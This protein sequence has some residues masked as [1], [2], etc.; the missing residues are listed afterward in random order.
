MAHRVTFCDLNCLN[1]PIRNI[2]NGNVRMKKEEN[3]VA[4]VLL[5]NEE[6]K[7]TGRWFRETK[8]LYCKGK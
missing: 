3:T 2:Y 1:P 6:A 4:K 8:L 7:S 5:G